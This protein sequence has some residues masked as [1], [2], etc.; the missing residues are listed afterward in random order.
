VGKDLVL[1]RESTIWA[2][3]DYDQGNQEK[4]L[5]KYRARITIVFIITLRMFDTLILSTSSYVPHR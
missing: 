3:E 4:G 1:E 5:M 2:K